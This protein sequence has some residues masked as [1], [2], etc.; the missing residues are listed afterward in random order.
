MRKKIVAT[1]VIL[2]A[3]SIA[4]PIV[5]AMEL[6]EGFLDIPWG[7]N[8]ASLQGFTK[9]YSKNPVDFYTNP[10]KAFQVKDAIL[11]DV[12]YGFADNRFFAVYIKIEDIETFSEIKKYMKS[13]YG[14]PKTSFAMKNEEGVDRWKHKDVK[15]KLKDNDRIGK[16]KL[17]FY[18]APLSEGINE[19][20]LEKYAD[21]RVRV[22][23]IE[24][25]KMPPS[26]PL[27]TF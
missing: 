27:L 3:I 20:Q 11:A 2:A 17:A 25:D 24:R 15:I 23:P 21:S 22:L 10:Q 14:I 7:A 18:Y 12:V 26:I 19:A 9:I 16:S 5:R 4:S 13:R 8:I 1:L 6:Q